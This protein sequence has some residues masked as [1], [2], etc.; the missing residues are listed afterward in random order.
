MSIKHLKNLL[1]KKLT[2]APRHIKRSPRTIKLTPTPASKPISNKMDEI[3]KSGMVENR[4]LAANTCYKR[5]EW[6][7]SHITESVKKSSSYVKEKIMER[8]ETIAYNVI[9]N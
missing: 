7:I 1:N 3:E 9:S 6:L 4:P 8:F 2:P 5:C